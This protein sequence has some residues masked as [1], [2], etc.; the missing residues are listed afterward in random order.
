MFY[1]EYRIRI[2]EGKRLDEFGDEL[3][4]YIK[5][6]ILADFMLCDDFTYKID[7]LFALVLVILVIQ[8]C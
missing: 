5:V 8:I 4:K 7:V 2:E 1:D 3:A 6:I